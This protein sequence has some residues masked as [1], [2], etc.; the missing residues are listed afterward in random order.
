MVIVYLILIILASVILGFFILIQ[1]PK[2]GGLSDSIGG[3]SNN[4]M[5]VRQTTD[6]L[7]KSTWILIGA[8]VVLSI[9]S[10]IIL[11]QTKNN[12]KS[13]LIQDLNTSP[14]SGTR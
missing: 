4:F 12:S 6:I 3:V 2:G 5:G 10:P 1:N 11:K 7:E 13:S 14:N 9:F 8:I